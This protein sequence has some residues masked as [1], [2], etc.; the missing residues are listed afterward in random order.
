VPLIEGVVDD[1]LPPSVRRPE[2][3]VGEVAGITDVAEDH[4]DGA[5]CAAPDHRVLAEQLL[6]GSDVELAQHE[7]LDQPPPLTGV[8]DVRRAIDDRL[9]VHPRQPHLD[10]RVLRI[11]SDLQGADL[12]APRVELGQH[13]P[14]LA[15][16]DGG[17]DRSVIEGR[18]LCD[19]EVA[20]RAGLRHEG[21]EQERLHQPVVRAE[22]VLRLDLVGLR[23][24][25][26]MR[27][28]EHW[29]ELVAVHIAG[30]IEMALHVVAERLIPLR[31]DVEQLTD[32]DEVSDGQLV[33]AIDQELQ[34]HA[35]RRSLTLKCRRRGHER[36]HKCR[37]ERI[38]RAEQLAVALLGHQHVKDLRERLLRLSERRIDLLA[39]R[40]VL[41]RKK[42]ALGDLRKV[43]VVELDAVETIVPVLERIRERQLVGSWQL[44]A[45][46]LDFVNR[47]VHVRRSVSAGE[48]DTPKSGKA[49][50]VPLVDQAA[51][52]LA[53]LSQRPHFTGP[54]DFV[55]ATVRG[56]MQDEKTMRDGLYAAM[57]KARIS[58]DRGTGKPFVFHDLHV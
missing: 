23:V 58:R 36:R 21:T 56:T 13:D 16:R 57:K 3:I 1:D 43:P 29:P 17:R 52:A 20:Q 47:L 19:V 5:L 53:G 35:Q 14:L 39:G 11:A 34:H 10:G 48:E 28:E 25:E 40:L 38:R 6:I 7:L 9:D 42:P 27:F 33:A 46:E 15:A 54:D 4:V 51:K 49:R 44:I 24:A 41:W 30:V 26:P 31:E 8:V 2:R 32:A 22:R 50:S 37:A 18:E 12:R 55:F 45:H